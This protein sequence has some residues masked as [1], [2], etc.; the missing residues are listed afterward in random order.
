MLSENKSQHAFSNLF[1]TIDM[2]NLIL[3]LHHKYHYKKQ[4]RKA[5]SKSETINDSLTH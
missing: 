1:E 4:A 2:I 3:L 5:I